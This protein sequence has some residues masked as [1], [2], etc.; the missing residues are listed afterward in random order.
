MIKNCLR[1][2]FDKLGVWNRLELA[3][4]VADHNGR[5]R[6]LK[7]GPPNFSGHAGTICRCG[8]QSSI[9]TTPQSDGI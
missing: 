9:T 2:V 1:G 7:A 6:L 5:H 4:Y 3:M 8:K